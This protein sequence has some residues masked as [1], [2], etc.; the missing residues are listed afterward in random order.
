MVYDAHAHLTRAGAG[1][2]S[3][4]ARSTTHSD[5]QQARNPGHAATAS[6]NVTDRWGDLVN[7]LTRLID[8]RI[9]QHLSRYQQQQADLAR[10]NDPSR[11]PMR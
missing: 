11:R 5:Q 8:Q 10:R 4:Q 2:L 6:L 1:L 7:A 3:S 9:Q